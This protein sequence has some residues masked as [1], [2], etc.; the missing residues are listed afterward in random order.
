MSRLPRFRRREA[1]YRDALLAAVLPAPGGD[2][3]ALEDLD[4]RA[5]W[6]EFDVV[7]PA[8]V[9]AGLRAASLTLGLLPRALG[10][11]RALPELS[12]DEREELIVR[13][14][15]ITGMAELVE[16]A[17]VV[18]GLAYFSDPA[19]QAAGRALGAPRE[20]AKGDQP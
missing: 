16:V 10:Y 20:S 4:L 6:D 2:L 1:Q 13:A 19:V 7:A 15:A 9:R 11:G 3:P 18:A 14:S 8:H 5:F 12:A 17:K